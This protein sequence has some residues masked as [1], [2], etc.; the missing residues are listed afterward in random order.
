[1]ARIGE[2]LVHHWALASSFLIILGLLMATEMKRKV[3]GFKDIPTDEAIRLINRD[4]AVVLDVRE[5]TEYRE[6]HIINAMHIPLGLLDARVNQLEKHKDRPIIVCCKA[7]QDSARAGV[8][9]RKHGF[10]PVYKLGGGI[11]AWKNANL[12]VER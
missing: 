4:N 5:D 6:G 7:G 1:M 10:N 11:A 3:L 12:P 2:F 9:L 8:T